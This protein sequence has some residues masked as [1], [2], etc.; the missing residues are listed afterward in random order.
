MKQKNPAQIA[1]HALEIQQLKIA[2]EETRAAL[3]RAHAT[4]HQLA[5]KVNRQ[6]DEIHKQETAFA[7]SVTPASTQPSHAHT[8]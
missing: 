6:A 2:H 4:F 8:N 1:I 3:V 5:E 7:A